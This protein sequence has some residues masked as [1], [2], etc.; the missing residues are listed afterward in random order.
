MSVRRVTQVN[1]GKNTPGVDKML[2][3]TP[4][5]RSRLVEELTRYPPRKR[6][7]SPSYGKER[8]GT[9]LGSQV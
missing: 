5:A 4:I 8:P 7:L 2:V 9:I 6:S 1:K 3:K